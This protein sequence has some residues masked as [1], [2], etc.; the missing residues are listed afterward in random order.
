MYTNKMFP[1]KNKNNFL[2]A[3]GKCKNIENSSLGYLFVRQVYKLK[4]FCLFIINMSEARN[5]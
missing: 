1:F 2:L 5:N 4:F 3:Y